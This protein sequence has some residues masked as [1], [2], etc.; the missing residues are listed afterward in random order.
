MLPLAGV[1]VLD[2]TRLLPGPFA[3]MV[4]ADLGADVVKVE[5]PR[6]GDWLRDLPPLVGDQSG[7]Y[8]VLNRSKRSATLDLRRPEGA[9][10]FLRL[11]A[12]ADVVLESF[13]PGVLDRLGVGWSAL[14][15]AS[16][17]LVLCSISGYGQTGP[18]V[19]R[20]GHD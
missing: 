4:L 19:E 11:A 8:H 7:P 13:R 2:L 20:P 17:R 16:P 15:A 10:A 5:D 18:N 12:R 9:A 14:R 1:R 6:G 3:S